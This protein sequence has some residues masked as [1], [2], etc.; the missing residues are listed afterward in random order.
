VHRALDEL[1][2]TEL[3]AAQ[4]RQDAMGAQKLV[5]DVLFASMREE[6]A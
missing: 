1:D 2:I 5:Q 6:D 3:R 4:H